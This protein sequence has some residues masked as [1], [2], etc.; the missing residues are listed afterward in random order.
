MTSHSLRRG[1]VAS[2]SVFPSAEG[3]LPRAGNDVALPPQRA[4]QPQ[5]GW[6]RAAFSPQQRAGFPV[7]EM[8]SRSLR[9]GLPSPSR[10][11]I[12]QR[13]PLS[14]GLASPCGK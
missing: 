13:F 9:R 8:T 1:G 6:H 4:P 11:G 3:W 2:C 10:G 12:V 5:Q 7:R 14:R